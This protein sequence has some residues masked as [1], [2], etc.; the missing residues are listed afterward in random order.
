MSKS[1]TDTLK[2][3][4]EA[5]AKERARARDLQ[6]SAKAAQAHVDEARTELVEAH[7]AV[8]P[9]AIKAAEKNQQAAL[10]QAEN[11]SVQA[12][13]ALLRIDRASRERHGY[14]TANARGLIAELQPQAREIAERLQSSAHE[15]VAADRAWGSLAQEVNHLLKEIPGASAIS[16]APSTHVLAEVARDIR[17]ALANGATV[18]PPTPHFAGLKNWETEQRKVAEIKREQ[19][20]GQAA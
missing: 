12:D 7:A 9:R 19:R 18:A 14:V 13:A 10:K 6:A 15:L 17:R 3:L 2:S 11:A 8:D 5:E 16:D 20:E 1:K 4:I